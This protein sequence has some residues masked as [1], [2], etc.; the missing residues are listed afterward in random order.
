MIINSR[1][2]R[3]SAAAVLLGLAGAQ[4]Q[5]ASCDRTCLEKTMGAY[6][7]AMVKH[8]PSGLK[9]APGFKASENQQP[10]TLGQGVWQSIDKVL[11]Q[12]QFVTDADSGEIGY[13]GV[14]QDAGKPAFLGIRLKVEN[15]AIA[16]AE[17]LVTQEGEGG[18]A[19]EPQGFIYREAPYLR[20]VPKAVRSSREQLL[21]TA[22]T[23][24]DVST[25]S[26]NAAL[27][28]YTVDCWH[29]ENGMNTDWE[30]FFMA[31]ELDK[32]GRPEYQPQ[33]FDGRIWTC[34]RE[35]YLSTTSW[36]A[37]R[38]RHFIVDQERGLVLNLILVDTI[39]PPR[40]GAGPRPPAGG[41]AAALD[42][43]AGPGP[44]P[45]GMSALGMSK[46]MGQSYTTQHF[47]VMRIVG[48]KIAREQDVMRILPLN[49][50]SSF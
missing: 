26:H 47:E 6:V 43:I 40:T 20:D 49:T 15:G 29:F 36:K 31:N 4:A 45:L 12:P 21:K 30:R 18:P 33:A 10:L 44:A 2:G 13:V 28:P 3:V 46:V 17:T 42:P 25:S 1:F 11:S 5:T 41:E 50:A 32:L 23:Y 9:L 27:I 14:I 39:A 19:F 48:G 38:D 35:A 8:D 24:W 16:E 34:A 22:N 37:A 7:A